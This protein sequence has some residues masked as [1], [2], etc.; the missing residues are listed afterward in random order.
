MSVEASDKEHRDRAR[1]RLEANVVVEAGAGTGKTT[2]LT[3]RILFLVLGWDHPEPIHIERVVALTFTEKAAGEIKLR[4]SDRLSEIAT[5]L[6]G[7]TA[8]DAERAQRTIAELRDHFGKSDEEI[9]V[10]ARAALEDLDKAPIGTIHS[11]CAQLLRLYPLESGVDPSFRVDDGEAF[12][13]LFSAQ[14][15]KWLDAELGEKPPRRDAWLELLSFVDLEELEQLGRN[16]CSEAVDLATLD[17]PDPDCAA[18]LRRLAERASSIP[19]GRPKPR[20]KIL[21]AIAAAVARLNAAADAATSSQPPLDATEPPPPREA[22]WPKNWEGEDAAAA[23]ADYERALAVA[24]ISG[25]RG[26]AVTRRAARLLRPFAQNFSRDFAR[27]GWVSF[28]G[29]LRRAR[30]LVRDQPQVREEVKRRFS[31][32][33]VDEFQDTDPLQ[34]E[35]LMYLVEKPGGGARSWREIEPAPGRVFVVGDPKQ[36]IYRFRGAD[37]AAYEGFIDRLRLSGALSCDLTVNFRSVPGVVEPV[38]AVFAK[39]MTAEPGAQPQ[40]KAITAARPPGGKDPAVQAIAVTDGAGTADAAAI[41]RAE[42]A[43]I[44]HWLQQ[45]AHVPGAPAEGRRALKDCAV[46]IRS[47]TFLPAL[48]DAFK[49]ADI[50]YAVE[51]ERFFYEAPE[52]SDFLNLLRVLHDSG[53][54]IAFSGLLRSPLVALTDKGLLALARAQALRYDR[55]PPAGI[56]TEDERKRVGAF[57]ATLRRLR[58]KAGRVALGDLVTQALEETNFVPFAARAYHG[59]QTVSN[60]WKLRRLAA[61]ASDR[62]GATLKEFAARVRDAA[63]ESRREGESPLADDNLE[64]V[65]ILTIHKSKGLEYPVVFAANLSGKPGGAQNKPATRPDR[66]GHLPLRVGSFASAVMALADVREKEMER[67]ESVRLLYVAMTRAR[68]QLFLLGGEKPAGGSLAS[69]LDSAGAWPG[70]GRAG[71]LPTVYLDVATVEP[72]A[73]SGSAVEPLA[74]AEAAAAIAGWAGREVWREAA[75]APRTISATSRA[76]ET[77]EP[78]VRPGRATLAGAEIGQICHRVLQMWDFRSGGDLSRSVTVARA[79]L[80]RRSPGSLWDLA[81]SEARLVLEGFLASPAA[82][83][84]G[85]S[86]IVAREIPFAYADGPSVVRGFIDMIYR[87]NGQITVIDFKSEHVDESSARKVRASYAKQGA[88]YAEAVKRAWGGA[89]EF[90]ILFLRRPEL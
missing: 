13:E 29:L 68:E 47:S 67:R 33:L 88:I 57:S 11:F 79:L 15:A 10:R 16:L 34:G 72:P 65:R 90:R 66:T 46:L 52:V 41:Q 23:L 8:P 40:Y 38:N 3:D 17:K 55:D 83:A 19:Q 44:A 87:A 27:R 24:K 49:A 64:A 56:L 82:R 6:S 58:S 75:R 12:E 5:S 80:E 28:D 69:H 1:F 71:I 62:R 53:D 36:S 63:R 61:E 37:I 77:L 39:A 4:L 59:Q 51:I 74:T 26:E 22:A 54:R 7:G 20:S 35:L 89:P 76:G 60:I 25:P 81:E 42:A 30:D 48:L 84:L 85:E 18:A 14:W 45:H 21:E 31:T 2:L 50:P 78:D 32:L 43:W 9:G 73:R 86:E 70:D